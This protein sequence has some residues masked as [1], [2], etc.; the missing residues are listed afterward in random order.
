MMQPTIPPLYPT[1]TVDTTC[2]TGTSADGLGFAAAIRQSL[3]A[4]HP[5]WA[6][7]SGVITTHPPY[8]AP[9][10]A[11]VSAGALRRPA[12]PTS[13]PVRAVDSASAAPR[14]A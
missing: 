11:P 10:A 1:P 8:A 5:G 6:T 2:G 4:A 7:I 9:A 3:I 12:N 14:T 13:N